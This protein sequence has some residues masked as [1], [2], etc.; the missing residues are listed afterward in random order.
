MAKS[1]DNRGRKVD[2]I[3]GLE[4]LVIT[5]RFSTLGEVFNLSGWLGIRGQ[6]L[7]AEPSASQPKNGVSD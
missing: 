4:L 1:L 6:S 2:T 5:N 7:E 3:L